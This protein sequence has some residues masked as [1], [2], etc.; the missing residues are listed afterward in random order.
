MAGKLSGL[1]AKGVGIDLI[2]HRFRRAYPGV[3]HI[4]YI[5]RVRIPSK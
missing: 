5:L 3:E 4:G 2:K 1:Q